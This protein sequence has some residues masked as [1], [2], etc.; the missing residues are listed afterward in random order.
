MQKSTGQYK[1]YVFATFVPFWTQT[2]NVVPD[3]ILGKCLKILSLL[4]TET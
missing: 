3:H 4:H 1:F 2:L